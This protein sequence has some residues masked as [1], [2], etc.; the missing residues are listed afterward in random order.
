MPGIC[1]TVGYGQVVP[2]KAYERIPGD[3]MV[4]DVRVNPYHA[5]HQGHTASGL[6]KRFGV[7]YLGVPPLGNAGMRADTW[8]P[9]SRGMAE[10][11]L[12]GLADLLHSGQSICLLCACADAR[13]CHRRFIAEALQE[14]I[15]GLEVRHL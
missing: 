8:E 14:R 9:I 2:D 11:N 1:Y 7:R 6:L 4:V 5:W 10:H 13:R 15:S 3:V 12:D